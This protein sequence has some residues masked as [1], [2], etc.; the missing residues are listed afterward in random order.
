MVN[1]TRTRSRETSA[2]GRPNLLE[3]TYSRYSTYSSKG[4]KGVEGGKDVKRT[5]SRT[6]SQQTAVDNKSLRSFT[7]VFRR[8]EEGCRPTPPAKL[9]DSQE[10]LLAEMLVYFRDRNT[11]PVS[12]NARD[13][14]AEEPPTDWEKLRMLSRESMLRYLRATK[15]DLNAAQKRLVETI[16]WRREFGVDSI[17]P[18]EV[19]GEAKSGKETVMGYDNSARPLHYMHPHRN[20]TKETPTQMR[21]AVWI[22]ESCIDLMPPGVEQLALL[23][24]FDNRSRNP[25]SIAN[26]KLMLY[27]LQNHYV[28]RLG[29]ALCINVPWVFKAFW[30]AIQGFI[31]PVTKSK[32]KFDEGI[33]EEVPLTQLSSDYGGLVEPTYHHD[34][35]WPDLVKLTKERRAA[36]LKRFKEQ[37]NSEVGA[38]EWVVRGGNDADCDAVLQKTDIANIVSEA[39]E[40]GALARTDSGAPAEAPTTQVSDPP[41]VADLDTAQS[42][43]QDAVNASHARMNAAVT[44]SSAE[45]PPLV[46]LSQT[47]SETNE[48][49]KTPTNE[50]CQNPLDRAFSTLSVTRSSG[51]GAAATSG[52]AASNTAKADRLGDVDEDTQ[53]NGTGGP[54]SPPTSPPSRSDTPLSAIRGRKEGDLQRRSGLFGSISKMV[55]HD[56]RNKSTDSAGKHKRN[57]SSASRKLLH[58]SSTQQVNVLFFAAARDAAG[59]SS[60]KIPLIATPLK[61]SEMPAL[62]HQSKG[63]KDPTRLMEVIA[64]SNWCVDQTMVNSEDTSTTQL[65]GGEDVAV[66]PPV[67][68]G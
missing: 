18:D 48:T 10:K 40:M 61:L 59:T 64:R 60:I 7:G 12:L 62:I 56:G 11:Y 37:C 6:N 30:S 19:E 63:I 55:H 42:S 36:M 1:P 34:Q 58:K 52:A 50:I 14:K 41:H 43:R 66:I 3:K 38:S 2:S 53:T 17:D 8:P 57:A 44:A 4:G 27:I 32:C 51:Q 33:K 28:E 9:S 47:V 23:I 67:S 13:G 39:D 31:D 68:G 16:A 15:W 49:F 5:S 45:P 26:A 35:Y 29:L 20:N 22:L 25:T 46:P 24:N 21:F 65:K 54:S